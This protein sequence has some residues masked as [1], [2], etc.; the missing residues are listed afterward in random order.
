M[1]GTRKRNGPLGPNTGSKWLQKT[2]GPKKRVTTRKPGGCMKATKFRRN[3]LPVR[4]GEVG[5]NKNPP[6]SAG[7]NRENGH[8]RFH[9]TK[10]ALNWKIG[11]QE[12]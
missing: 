5:W 7:A 1:Q 12:N 3:G 9:K 11:N 8:R 4:E 10:G 2:G 6:A